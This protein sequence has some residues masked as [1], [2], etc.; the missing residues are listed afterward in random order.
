MAGEQSGERRAH[1]TVS[2]VATVNLTTPSGSIRYVTPLET[3]RAP[4]SAGEDALLRIVG[5]HE[6]TI[7]EFSVAARLDSELMEGDD[8]RGIIDAIIDV[9]REARR[10]DLV[11]GGN[12]VDRHRIGGA[13]PRAGA[14]RAESAPVGP[15][16]ADESEQ[17]VTYSVQASTDHGR[18]WQTVAIGLKTP[19]T[20]IDRSQF[21]AGQT[22]QVRVVATNGLQRSVVM[23]DT[24]RN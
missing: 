22:I 1:V 9:D 2:V 24:L 5:A 4:K 14:R 18:S 13:M 11:I 20:Q 23:T 7:D 19:S 16:A 8:L 6:E 21:A 3:K 12:V 17:V 10:I 15:E